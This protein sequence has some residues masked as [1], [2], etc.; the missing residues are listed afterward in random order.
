MEKL[1][2]IED[3]KANTGER[4]TPKETLPGVGQ[5]HSQKPE[6]LIGHPIKVAQVSESLLV[7]I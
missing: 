1:D 3:T 4:G 2:S 7:L 5:P 6:F